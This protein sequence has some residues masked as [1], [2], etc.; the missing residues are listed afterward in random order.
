MAYLG[1]QR[2]LG[3]CSFRLCERPLL[4]AVVQAVLDL[5]EDKEKEGTSFSGEGSS[6]PGTLLCCSSVCG[7]IRPW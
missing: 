6:A 3:I 2:C 5:C 7:W 4:C 1:G